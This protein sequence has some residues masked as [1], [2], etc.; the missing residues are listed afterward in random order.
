MKIEKNHR[1]RSSISV[2]NFLHC[3]KCKFEISLLFYYWKSKLFY[4][5]ITFFSYSSISRRLERLENTMMSFISGTMRK[6]CKVRRYRQEEEEEEEVSSWEKSSELSCRM[7]MKNSLH[8][9]FTFLSISRVGSEI[10]E[11]FTFLA[12]FTVPSELEAEWMM[13]IN[14]FSSTWLWCWVVGMTRKN[15]EIAESS[16]DLS[17]SD[18]RSSVNSE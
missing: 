17:S 4:L 16:T 10:D 3:F 18:L 7:K 9:V 5:S 15:D 1:K 13:I 6:V 12:P 8:C 2:K 11:V 14:N